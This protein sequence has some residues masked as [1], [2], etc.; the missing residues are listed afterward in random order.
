LLVDAVVELRSIVAGELAPKIGEM[1]R[2]DVEI[3][4]KDRQRIGGL[5]RRSYGLWI[6]HS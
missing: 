6:R 2:K 1:D 3:R 4:D 5:C